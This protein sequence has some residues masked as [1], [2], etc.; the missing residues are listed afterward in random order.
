MKLLCSHFFVLVCLFQKTVNSEAVDRMTDTSQ[1]TGTHK[2]RFDDSGKGRGIAGRD[3]AAKGRGSVPPLVGSQP[4]YVEGYK[5]E[6]SYQSPKQ[7]PKKVLQEN[8]I[9]LAFH[10]FHFVG[11]LCGYQRD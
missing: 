9:V 7:K 5:S 2:E 1:Y 3:A 8:C 11:H 4:A 10:K 6:G